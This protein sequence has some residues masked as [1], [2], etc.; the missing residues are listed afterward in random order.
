VVI[1]AA[2]LLM[3]ARAGAIDWSAVPEREILAFHTGQASYE[4]TLI[5]AS[6]SGGPKMREGKT[7]VDCHA[8]EEKKIGELIAKGEKAEPEPGRVSRP[9][10]P[11]RVQF[12]QDA[13]R[14]HVRLRWDAS[15]RGAERSRIS[16][17]FDDGSMSATA[18]TGC[19]SSC[20]SDLIEMSN[21]DAGA[22]LTKYLVG[23]RTKVGRSG[24]GESYKAQTELDAQLAEGKFLELW[25][26][27][28]REGAAPVLTEGFV[29]EKRHDQSSPQVAVEGGL[30]DGEW[31][32]VMSRSLAA[33]ASGYKAFTA[34]RTYTFGLSVHDGADEGRFHRVSLQYTLGLGGQKADFN[35][36]KQ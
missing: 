22:E 30:V 33:P 16:L 2:G 3:A 7:C 19:W 18:V 28:L 15:G 11:I 26:A 29:L 20:H 23:S 12:A 34:D 35:A 17:L 13:E 25:G 24:G 5:E 36:A 27:E 4:W 21:A 9:W 6:H 14:L 31:N 1:L 8:D 10:S 32:L